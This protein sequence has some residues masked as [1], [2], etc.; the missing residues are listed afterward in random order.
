MRLAFLL[1]I[2]A[3]G[4]GFAVQPAA[5]DVVPGT[6]TAETEIRNV[7]GRWDRAR[8]QHDLRVLAEI[9]DSRFVANE[10]AGERIGRDEVLAGCAPG[11]GARLITRDGLEIVLRGATATA[12]AR[13][14]TIGTPAGPSVGEVTDELAVLVREGTAWRLLS[15]RSAAAAAPR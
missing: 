4:A 10:P 3:C 1:A 15:T 5:A 9:L 6:P 8:A 13:V 11:R 7:L 14:T 12:R 2:A